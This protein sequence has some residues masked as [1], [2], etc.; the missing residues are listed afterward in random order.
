MYVEVGQRDW[1]TVVPFVTFTYNTVSKNTIGLLPFFLLH[2]HKTETTLDIIFH[3]S[4][5][6]GD[7]YIAQLSMRAEESPYLS[8]LRTPQEQLKDRLRYV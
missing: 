8:R 1:D 5:N 4:N 2:G 6:L 3:I 7:N